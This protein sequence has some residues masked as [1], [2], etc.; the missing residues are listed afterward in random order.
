MICSV[1]SLNQIKTCTKPLLAPKEPLSIVKLILDWGKTL[2]IAPDTCDWLKD[3]CKQASSPLSVPDFIHKGCQFE[4]KRREAEGFS[5]YME[6]S[7]NEG[8]PFIRK[9]CSVISF[10]EKCNF[11]TLSK[12]AS[13]RLTLIPALLQLIEKV[14]AVVLMVDFGSYFVDFEDDGEEEK[15]FQIERVVSLIDSALSLYFIVTGQFQLIVLISSTV[16][17]ILNID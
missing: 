8:L 1:A 2:S 11:Y 17:K 13:R 14:S 7:L 9:G 15:E 3:I 4:L 5:G 16:N 12:A 6:L 10:F